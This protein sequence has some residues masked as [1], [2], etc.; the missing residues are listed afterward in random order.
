MPFPLSTVIFFP[1]CFRGVR[2]KK[3]LNPSFPRRFVPF[4]L[5]LFFFPNFSVSNNSSGNSG[6]GRAVSFRIPNSRRITRT[7]PQR[8]AGSLMAKPETPKMP[9]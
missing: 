1:W 8:G 2:G 3:S 9:F 5:L 4:F 7:I 6:S